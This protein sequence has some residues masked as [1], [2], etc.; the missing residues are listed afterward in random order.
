ML[1]PSDWQRHL[2]TH[3]SESLLNFFCLYG[4]V[5][6]K[7]ENLDLNCGKRMN[8]AFQSHIAELYCFQSFFEEVWLLNKLKSMPPV[9][10]KSPW[11]LGG[12]V[13]GW[14]ASGHW[15]G[16]TFSSGWQIFSIPA[17][18]H[19]E[20]GNV[21]LVLSPWAQA[22]WRPHSQSH[23]TLCEGPTAGSR[24]LQCLHSSEGWLPLH[25]QDPAQMLPHQR[26]L[27]WPPSLSRSNE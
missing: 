20:D 22:D 2:L 26:G 19:G 27:S 4:S 1:G 11:G 7:H 24:N 17:R 18:T 3:G 10:A 15:A 23:S 13:A 9:S 12:V 14:G 16:Y 21:S 25:T 5:F 6:L 8:F